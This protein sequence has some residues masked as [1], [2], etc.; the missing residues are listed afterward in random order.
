MDEK[1]I[2]R[3]E[4]THG[5]F[6]FVM[7]SH[8]NENGEFLPDTIV[9]SDPFP[10]EPPFMRKRSSPAALRFHKFTQNKDPKKYFF[11]E[12]LLYTPFREETEIWEKLNGD[13]NKVETEIQKVK[14]QVMEFLESNDEARLFVE[15]IETARADQIAA[16]LDPEYQQEN[17]DCVSEGL[18]L[19]PD[20]QHLN[21]DD[22]DINVE[23]STA[24]K[25]FKPIEI[26]EKSVL[27]EKTRNLDF[28]QR[29]VIE[30]GIKYCRI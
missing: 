19:H 22:L 25:Q 4:R 13:I 16:E 8:E 20:F 26:D 29:K 24:E 5:K 18:V 2:V 27:L 17:D 28:Y 6:H 30:K 12:C 11:S 21:P 14:S 15:E 9:L 23:D 1:Q 10:S 7:H 3:K